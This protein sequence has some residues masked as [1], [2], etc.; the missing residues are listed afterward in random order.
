M[1]YRYEVVVY[2]NNVKSKDLL[3][4]TWNI[5]L[6]SLKDGLLEQAMTDTI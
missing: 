1:S 6:R 5:L 3:A 4:T 2:I